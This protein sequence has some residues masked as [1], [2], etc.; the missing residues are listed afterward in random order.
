MYV[1]AHIR[2][3]CVHEMSNKSTKSFILLLCEAR[4]PTLVRF[5]VKGIV[6]YLKLWL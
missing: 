5:I 2:G 4:A 1:H 3:S 6:A